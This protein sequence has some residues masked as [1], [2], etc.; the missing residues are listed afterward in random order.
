MRF[1]IV[2]S[3]ASADTRPASMSRAGED[4]PFVDQVIDQAYAMRDRAL[5]VRS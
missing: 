4:V 2:G 1:P 5:T 3:G